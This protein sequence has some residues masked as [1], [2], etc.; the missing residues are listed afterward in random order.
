MRTLL[1]HSF[2]FN[3]LY[4]AQEMAIFLFSQKKA[5]LLPQTNGKYSYKVVLYLGPLKKL[6]IVEISLV[7]QYNTFLLWILHYIHI[8]YILHNI[9]AKHI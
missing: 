4:L 9:L 8:F 3:R 6:L 2:S 7:S 1:D 5:Q